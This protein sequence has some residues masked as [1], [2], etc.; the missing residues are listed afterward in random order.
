MAHVK[1]V[2]IGDSPPPP[3]GVFDVTARRTTRRKK[4]R[5][6]RKYRGVKTRSALYVLVAP[7]ENLVYKQEW[8]PE[9]SLA[10]NFFFALSFLWSSL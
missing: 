6:R 10:W 7:I 3:N 4:G 5:R 2:R 8:R 9:I 1:H